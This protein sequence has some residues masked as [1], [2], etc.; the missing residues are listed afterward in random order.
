MMPVISRWANG[1]HGLDAFSDPWN[2]ILGLAVFFLA[3]L[4]GNMY[5]INNIRHEGLIL[6]CRRQL[7]SDAVTF[8]VVFSGFCY[9]YVAEGWVC[10]RCRNT[11]H[12]YGTL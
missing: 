4:L 6:R 7:I 1:W 2:L 10:C 8:P 11:D 12:C 9:P 3:R 5:F